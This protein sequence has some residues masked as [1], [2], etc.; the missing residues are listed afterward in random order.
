MDM[1]AFDAVIEPENLLI[2]VRDLG[3][4]TGEVI[5]RHKAEENAQYRTDS[6]NSNARFTDFVSDPALVSEYVPGA[7]RLVGQYANSQQPLDTRNIRD[8]FEAPEHM[9]KGKRRILQ[10]GAFATGGAGIELATHSI[11]DSALGVVA[12]GVSIGVYKLGRAIRHRLQLNKDLGSIERAINDPEK[13]ITLS[14][15]V[16]PVMF[17]TSEYEELK[18]QR[19]TMSDGTEGPN[20]EDVIN[21][22]QRFSKGK[23]R[24]WDFG[25]FSSKTSYS[26]EGVIINPKLDLFETFK[27]TNSD[28]LWL[29]DED[30]KQLRKSFKKGYVEILQE[31]A[32]YNMNEAIP[33]D[34]AEDLLSTEFDNKISLFRLPPG[35]LL[36]YLLQYDANPTELW[37]QV[38]PQ[39]IQMK[40]LQIEA[41]Q[42]Q[43]ALANVQGKVRA[44]G[45]ELPEDTERISEH[46]NLLLDLNVRQFRTMLTILATAMLRDRAHNYDDMREEIINMSPTE[47]AKDQLD[48]IKLFNTGINALLIN[49]PAD[50]E[51]TTKLGLELKNYLINAVPYLD[52]DP[53][54]YNQFLEGMWK[55]FPQLKPV[56][57]P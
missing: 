23:A 11:L 15:S 55:R 13:R 56:L 26:Y 30:E 36:S 38:L 46:I 37:N 18:S 21:W 9:A 47:R 41:G 27:N 5:F 19:I 28:D 44:S 20:I 8:Y 39:T 52:G 32:R 34:V 17:K 14:N 12:G 48:A 6:P 3:Q 22:A 24:I 51:E 25:G 4:R 50:D 33:K 10:L 45:I 29:E 53:T 43:A 57:N 2:R 40:A 42:N 1:D 49:M 54:T 16:S 7:V 31:F 35:L